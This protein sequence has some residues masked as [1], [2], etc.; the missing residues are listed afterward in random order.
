MDYQKLPTTQ[1]TFH[2]LRFYATIKSRLLLLFLLIPFFCRAEVWTPEN[3]PMPY[4]QNAFHHV[5]NPDGVL[6]PAIE[7]SINQK[8]VDLEQTRGVQAIVVAVERVEDANAYQFGMDLARKYGIGSK[9]QN[10]GLVIV[11]A[12][13]DRKYYILTGEGLEGTLP[14]AICSRVENRIMKPFLK[15]GD[16]D[17]AMLKSVDALVGYMNGDESLEAEKEEEEDPLVVAFIAIFVGIIVFAF[18]AAVQPK[19]RCPKCGK[20]QLRKIQQTYVKV[21]GK[22]CI[23]TL[24][25]CSVCGYSKY[26]HDE[27][28]NGGGIGR[29]TS[30]YPPLFSGG[31]GGGSRGGGGFSGGSFG[32]GSFG[33]GGAGGSF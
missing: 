33:G 26:T 19:R 4:L 17:N 7:D 32:G 3:L 13:K 5:C 8:L 1:G 11:L 16:W 24:W 10:T 23:R 2:F 30:A 15:Q 21:N 18:I 22:W 31:L 25:R 29:N 14:D 6:S 9:K 12:T 28:N 27:P 20:R